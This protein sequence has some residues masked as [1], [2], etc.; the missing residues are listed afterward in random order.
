M[1]LIARQNEPEGSIQWSL[2][3]GVKRMRGISQRRLGPRGKFSRRLRT[4]PEKVRRLC[5]T[6][7]GR[8]NTRLLM[9]WSMK[10][11]CAPGPGLTRKVSLTLPLPYSRTPAIWPSPPEP[12]GGGKNIIPAARPLYRH[13]LSLNSSNHGF[14]KPC[15]GCVKSRGAHIRSHKDYRN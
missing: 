7:S 1:K 13:L 15:R 5:M 12:V 4:C 9:R 14:I 10:G 3:S 11:F 8:R 6:S 2:R